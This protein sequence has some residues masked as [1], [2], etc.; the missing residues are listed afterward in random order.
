MN[1][2][3]KL[4]QSYSANPFHLITNTPRSAE[5]LKRAPRVV[6]DLL[7]LLLTRGSKFKTVWSRE[8]AATSRKETEKKDEI[9]FSAMTG[10]AQPDCSLAQNVH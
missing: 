8:S 2:G 1:A 4:G 5:L 6:L 9:T 7:L 3:A 10:G